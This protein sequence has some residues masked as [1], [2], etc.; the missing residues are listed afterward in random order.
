MLAKIRE[1]TQGIIASVILILIVIPFAF[2]GINSYF[3]GGGSV[4]VAKVEGVDITQQA[5]RQAM[6]QLRGV[7]PKLLEDRQMRQMVLEGLIDQTLLVRDAENKGY[8]I[9]DARLGQMIRE[10]PYFQRD[11]RFDPDLYQTLL[12]REGIG[13]REF[14]SRRRSEQMIGQLRAGLSDSGFV[15]EADLAGVVRLLAQEREIAVATIGTEPFLTRAVVGEAEAAQYYQSHQ[16]QFSTPEQVRIE[17]LRL[18]AEGLIENY[19][20]GAEELKRAYAEEAG[21]YVVPEKRRASHVLIQLAPQAPEA[22]AKQAAAK[23]EDIARQARAGNDFAQ[24]AKQ[25]SD[26]KDSGAKGG[27]LGE[28]RRGVLPKELEDAIYALKRV[29]ELA[30]P[31]RTSYG[32][33]LARLTAHTPEKRKSFAEARKELVDLVRKRRG[34]ERFLELSEKFRNLV[35]EQPD[36]LKPAAE[37]LGLAVQQS[38]WFSRAGGSGLTAQSRIVEA[39]FHPDIRG[40]GRNSDAIE[41]GADA[42]VA[43]RVIGHRPESARPLSEVRAQ[44]ERVLREERAQ[45]AA[46]NLGEGLLKEL[47]AGAKLEALAKNHGLKLQPPK[48]ATRDQTAGLDRRIVEAAFQAPRPEGGRP[49]YGGVALGGQGYALFAVQR[50]K[51]PDLAKADAVLKDKVRKVLSARRGADYYANYRAGLRKAADV[52][53]NYDKL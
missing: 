18:S 25:H 14:E 8:R 39:A 27:D 29:G 37:A 3:E 19:R 41:V 51:E 7:D 32:W 21:R 12:R 47:R 45:A 34:E 40:Q 52:K 44:I 20:P 17:Y 31:V 10:L 35:Y 6:E 28:I 46:R 11:G 22:E 53:I 1:K 4:A 24:L 16:D 49:A 50:V 43:L 15:T 2:W 42:L 48:S 13:M 38:D 9:G 36:S 26:D 30:P 23:I 33:H 5:Y